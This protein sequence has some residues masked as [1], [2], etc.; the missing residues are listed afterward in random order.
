MSGI[1]TLNEKQKAYWKGKKVEFKPILEFHPLTAA[2]ENRLKNE[3]YTKNNRVG[4]QKL[5]DAVRQPS[6][7]SPTNKV[8]FSPTR[9]QVQA[10]LLKQLPGS[11]D[12]Q[13]NRRA[14]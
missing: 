10:W 9:K 11:S 1:K 5:Y 13:H 3:Y 4:F 6:G 7:K 12:L 14:L 2:E 8:M